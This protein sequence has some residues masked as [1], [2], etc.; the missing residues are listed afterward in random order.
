VAAIGEYLYW[1]VRGGGA[2]TGGTVDEALGEADYAE[3]SVAV[4]YDGENSSPWNTGAV[5]EQERQA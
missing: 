2:A 4:E 1:K 5:R 3:G